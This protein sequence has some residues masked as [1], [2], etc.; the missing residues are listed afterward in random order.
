MGTEALHILSAGQHVTTDRSPGHPDNALWINTKDLTRATGWQ[1]KPEGLC[2]DDVCMLVAP[3]DRERLVDGE[4]VCASALWE[5]MGRPVLHDKARSTWMLGEAA[6]D[7]SR[8]L[9]SLEAPDFTLPDITGKLHS[10]SDYRG[11][12]VFLSTWASW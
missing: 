4:A 10:L 12:K 1:L 3:T 11:K 7:R 6:A 9:E 8:E 2:R 5:A